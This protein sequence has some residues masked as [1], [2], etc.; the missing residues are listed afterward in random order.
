M[1]KIINVSIKDI[2]ESK[3]YAE[4]GKILFDKIQQILKDENLISIDMK[5]VESVPT[6]FMNTSFG[7]L[8]NIYGIDKVKESL[9]FKNITNS[10]IQRIRKYFE[11]YRVLLDNNKNNIDRLQKY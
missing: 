11:D 7:D 10:M 8:I 9:Y 2:L 6:S 4:A 5:D 3:T 1:N